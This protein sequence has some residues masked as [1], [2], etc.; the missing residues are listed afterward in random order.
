MDPMGIEIMIRNTLTAQ[1]LHALVATT[2]AL[3]IGVLPA[4]AEDLKG[5]GHFGGSS[6]GTRYSASADITPANA[7]MQVDRVAAARHL[8]A[9]EVRNLVTQIPISTG[10]ILATEQFYAHVPVDDLPARTPHFY[11]WRTDGGY[12]SDAISRA[13]RR[14]LN[15]SVRSVRPKARRKAGTAPESQQPRKVCSNASMSGCR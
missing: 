12:T 15:C 4:Q 10:G 5:W 8:P 3:L 1:M 9:A 13:A 6:Y 2:A 7:Y 14:Q 11:R